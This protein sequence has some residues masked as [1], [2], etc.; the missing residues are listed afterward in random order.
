MT[1]S[2]E[3]QRTAFVIMP[4][5]VAFDD[6]YERFIRS[7]LTK[8]GFDVTRADEVTSSASVMKTIIQSIENSCLIVADLTDAN[9]NVYYELALAHAMHKPVIALAQDVEDL[10]FDIKAYR[11]IHYSRDFTT[12]D[13]ARLE[14]EKTASGVLTNETLFGNPYSD[15]TG[16]PVVPSCR[17]VATPDDTL[18]LDDLPVDQDDPPGFIDHQADFE[19]GIEDLRISVE[20]ISADA[21]KLTQTMI[22]ITGEIESL[23]DDPNPPPDRS[24][25]Q[26]DS[27][28]HMAQSMNDYAYSLSRENDNYGRVVERTRPALEATLALR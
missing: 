15:H 23:N 19:Q 9:P 1:S 27:I 18:S 10:P 3:E 20:T 26:R 6:V 14:L 5:G 17:A 21:N 4:F 22:R 7:S 16:T 8:A 12:M 24:R 11:V 2:T 13:K 28:R 25:R